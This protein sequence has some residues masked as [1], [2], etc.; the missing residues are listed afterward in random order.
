MIG[1]LEIVNLQAEI[2]P[3]RLR[4]YS[5]SVLLLSVSFSLDSLFSFS[6]FW[7]SI[8]NHYGHAGLY[9]KPKLPYIFLDLL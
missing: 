1:S 5:S 6:P 2:I 9:N 8:T 3:F 4:Y 7:S